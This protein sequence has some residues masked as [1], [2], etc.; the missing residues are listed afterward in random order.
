MLCEQAGV[1][2]ISIG[3][4]SIVP[5][6]KYR[7]ITGSKFKVISQ[8]S[9]NL[10]GDDMF[11]DIKTAIDSGCDIIQV[12]GGQCD[13]LV[14]TNRV[15][16]IGKM[17]DFVRSQ[18][19]VAGLGAHTIDS[20]LIC[21]ENGII[22]DYYMHT[23]HHDN[24]WSAHPREFR[25]KYEIL[26]RFSPDHNKYH[27]N[28]FCPFPERTIEFLNRIKTPVMGYKVL[29]AGAIRPKDG[30]NWAFES[31]ADFICVGMFDFQVVNDVNICIDVLQ[32]LKNRTRAW[33]S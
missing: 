28:L 6:L 3:Y 8:T 16:L 20:L 10:D 5:I 31:G 23:M 13:R 2:A 12:H 30:F 33:C 26:S 22:P 19:Y 25:D 29:A 32:N 24:Y 27:D 18:G 4:Q 7:K 21:E 9:L 14:F 17:I 1:N 15:G 11:R